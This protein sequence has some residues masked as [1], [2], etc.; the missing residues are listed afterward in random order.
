MKKTILS[1]LMLAIASGI[2]A[3]NYLSN[4]E[5]SSQWREKSITVK[6]GGQAPH[7]IALLHA[8]HQAL[9]TWVVGEVL[10]QADHP[11]QDTRVDGTASI[12]ED[13]DDYRILIDRRNG[14]VDLSSQ[15]DINQMEAGVW[16]KDNGHRIF[17]VSLYEQHDPVQNLLCWY[18]YDPATQTMKPERSPLDD[19]KPALPSAEVGWSLPMKGTDFIIREY[20]PGLPGITHVYKW[21]RK[22][23]HKGETQ[24]P[25]FEYMPSVGS[26]HAEAAGH[27]NHVWS[28]YAL[29]DLT[30][31][32]WP[33][34]LLEEREGGQ[35]SERI[36][37]ACFKGNL[38]IIATQTL[39]GEKMNVFQLPQRKDN[40]RVAVQHRDMAG[41]LW[42]S[43][44]T[45][46]NVMF[47]VSD[48]PNFSKASD[49]IEHVVTL[50][51][52]FGGPDE[53]T[54]IINQLGDW[55]DLPSRIVWHELTI[56]DEEEG[57]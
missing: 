20:Y 26:T 35:M 5:V 42:Y 11:A 55:I 3:Q 2:T 54:E 4:S 45:G 57:I 36:M 50:E 24:M 52:G 56:T 19:F 27:C 29:A 25:N 48:R 10:K 44:L 33:V 46:N 41:G 16:R 12:Y 30:G 53:T 34:L 8:F 39:D 49:E 6:N 43:I 28:H 7:I 15:T 32:G 21:D 18:D 1:I 17:A 37:L 47:T 13:E 23:F 40:K 51:E 31:E 9:P 14:Y 22:Q 38:S